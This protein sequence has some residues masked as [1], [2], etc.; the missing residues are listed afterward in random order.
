MVL[1]SFSIIDHISEIKDGTKSQTTRIPRKQRSNGKPAYSV[2]EKVQLYY[3]PRMK[4]TCDNCIVTPQPTPC[5]HFHSEMIDCP[6]HNNFFGE[7]EIIEILH[8]HNAPYKENGTEV[9]MGCT[10]GH[11]DDEDRKAWAVADGFKNWDEA[12]D[13]FI[14]AKKDG[15][16]NYWHNRNYDVIVWDAKPIVK[17]WRQL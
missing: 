15:Y 6:Y 4:R 11:L 14:G 7:S 2:G 5:A 12:D 16:D 10:I 9:W 8:Y 3:R 17:R 13:Y 1:F